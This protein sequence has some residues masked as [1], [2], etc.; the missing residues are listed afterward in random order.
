MAYLDELAK[1]GDKAR[2]QGEPTVDREEISQLLIDALGGEDAKITLSNP[3]GE[4]GETTITGTAREV[5]ENLADCLLNA[6]LS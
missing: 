1:D 6:G 3:E 5:A 4:A 2:T